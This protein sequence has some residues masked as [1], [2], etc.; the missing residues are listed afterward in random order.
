M[1]EVRIGLIG[2][3]NSG[4]STIFNKLTGVYQ[5]VGNWPG[6]T[7]E[8]IERNVKFKD[9]HFLLID[10][11]GTQTLTPTSIE[12]EIA[13]EY[14]I[15]NTPDVIIQVASA[16]DLE[17]SIYLS[18]ELIEL[19]IPIVVALNQFDEAIK[20]GFEI[21]FK[22]LSEILGVPVIP[23][24]AIKGKGVGELVEKAFALAHS[25]SKGSIIIDENIRPKVNKIM[26]IIKEFL[27]DRYS[28][29][30][31]SLKLLE[32]DPWA[33]KK[34][35][36][37]G[38][39][40]RL[41]GVLEE[42]KASIKK[43]T[44]LHPS[45]LIVNKRR[46]F[47]E[48][49]ANS[50][51]KTKPVSRIRFIESLDS[52]SIS[53]YGY[54]LLA[55]VMA[56]VFVLTLGVGLLF[57]DVISYIFLWLSSYLVFMITDPLL[58]AILSGVQLSLLVGL[59]FIIPVVFLFHF[60]F[61]FLDDSGYLPRA[62]FLIDKAMRRIGLNGKAFIPLLLGY[63]C[64]VPACVSCRILEG[65]KQRFVT[66]L[67]ITLVPCVSRTITIYGLVAIYIGMI[68]ALVIYLFNLFL[69][70]LIGVI[71]G[72]LVNLSCE[73]TGLIMILPPYRV[74]LIKNVLKK[75]WARAKDFVYLAIPIIIIGAVFLKI[76]EVS[77]IIEHMNTL[78]D[79][80]FLGVFGL[81]GFVLSPLLFGVIRKEFALVFLMTT[82]K[83]NPLSYLSPNQIIVFTLIT[84]FYI[85]CVATIATLIREL[86][87]RK[88]L[89][90]IGINL[91]IV[92]TV[93]FSASVI[94]SLLS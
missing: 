58:N 36:E 52:L 49:I 76:L 17:R 90:I 94:L 50:V 16:I 12:E 57:K 35:S 38:A 9:R 20:Q 62:A 14:M 47:A 31:F 71:V 85:P 80:L 40:S 72:R 21:D 66:S 77:G 64:D 54:I 93:G 68:H 42:E 29:E 28:L 55:I 61:S 39:M 19:G 8:I 44:G 48:K 79:P 84:L 30:W 86:R 89:T 81:P 37:L 41:K 4:K 92:I 70:L 60:F 22:K 69:V 74:P 83:G 18:L 11:P 7:V 67:M 51:K 15:E 6:K 5:I 87:L 24:V 91:L 3:P 88:T 73:S 26:S 2:S 10:F 59:S 33:T 27:P 23:T 63:G 65:D 46:L 43:S 25:K 45:L 13:R 34:I 56:T 1:K 32:D 53:S 75:T 82:L 78:F